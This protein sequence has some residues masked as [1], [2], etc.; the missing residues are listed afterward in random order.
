MPGF[1]VNNLI[2]CSPFDLVIN[3]TITRFVSQ[4]EYYNSFQNS[5]D[6]I[7]LNQFNFSYNFPEV[8]NYYII[9]KLIGTNNCVTI[10]DT[11][12]I[13]V[14]PG[15]TN[16][17][18][19]QLF[20]ASYLDNQ[21][22]E[23]LWNAN[24]AARNYHLFSSKDGNTYQNILETN[25]TFYTHTIKTPQIIYYTVKAIDSCGTPTITSN[26]AKPIFLETNL[27]GQNEK[28]ILDFTAYEKWQQNIQ[29]YKVYVLDTLGNSQQ[30]YI[31]NPTHFEDEKI[32]EYDL[33]R[34]CYQIT[35]PHP[36]LNKEIK[37]NTSCIN[38]LPTI[39][40]PNS[41]T[42]NNDGLN[43]EFYP[44]I[45]GIESYDLYIYNRWGQLVGNFN[46]NQHWNGNNNPEGVYLYYIRA[47]TSTGK[48]INGKG[49][50]TL[51]R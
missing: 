51:L 30:V 22:I 13:T 19:T 18:S 6:T 25:D 44:S 40:I 42:P 1:T 29:N 45:L 46:K 3:D 16:Q 37:S 31:T 15:I 9:Q 32:T 33:S 48:I 8:G 28:A 47:R 23:L 38:V 34:I 21:H 27:F 14:R 43:E 26:F 35:I 10:R 50:I 41:F 24:S 5:W 20:Y 4:K 49:N 17:D 2:G 12:K 39:Y 11:A 36:T 7:P